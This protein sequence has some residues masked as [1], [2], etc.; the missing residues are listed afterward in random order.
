MQFFAIIFNVFNL[1]K[2]LLKRSNNPNIPLSMEIFGKGSAIK[3]ASARFQEY[4]K[5]TPK[6][7]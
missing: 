3:Y 7:E 4:P 6:N 5:E 1:C 2:H